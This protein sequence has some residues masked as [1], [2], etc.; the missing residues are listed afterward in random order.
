MRYAIIFTHP[1]RKQLLK[2]PSAVQG[3]IGDAI[4]GL[5]AHPRPHGVETLTGLKDTYRIRIGDYRVVYAIRDDELLILVIRI[6]HRR[7]VYRQL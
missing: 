2:L 6:G 5:S 7:D 4:D 1:A 3:R